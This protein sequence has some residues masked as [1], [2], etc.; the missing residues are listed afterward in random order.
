MGEWNCDWQMGSSA[1]LAL[2]DLVEEVERNFACDVQIG[3]PWVEE[4]GPARTVVGYVLV[5][6]VAWDGDE[7]PFARVATVGRAPMSQ[8]VIDFHAA[9]LNGLRSI[10]DTLVNE[11]IPFLPAAPV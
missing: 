10:A 4:V 6:A 7:T 8:D 9:A 11:P 2:Y 5:V 1:Q 3:E